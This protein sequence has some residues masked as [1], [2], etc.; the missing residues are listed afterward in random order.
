MD[1]KE[2]GEFNLIGRI[3]S[4]VNV[5]TGI[6]GIGD[7]CAVLPQ[8]DSFSTLVSTDMLVEGTHF[9]P[10]ADPYD[11]GWKSAAVNLSDIAA[12]GGKPEGTLLAFALTDRV[13]VGF[14]DQFIKGYTELSVLFDAPL[15]GGDTTFSTT[16]ISIC[17]TVLGSCPS[18]REMKRDGAKPGDMVCVTGTLGDSAAGLRIL[19][20]GGAS[21][22]MENQLVLRHLRPVPRVKE[23]LALASSGAL[24]SM[25]DISDGIG[26]DL[27]HILEAS[28]VGAEIDCSAIPLSAELKN[29]CSRNGLDPLELAIGGG[30]DYELLFTVPEAGEKS[31]DVPHHIIGRITENGLKWSDGKDYLGFRHF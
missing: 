24:R 30:E 9:L 27:R 2:L 12:M 31:L 15:L 6:T 20:G 25:M 21:D 23:G 10:D 11:L 5:P 26:S 19:L 16:G 29:Y 7:D 18:G 13:D 14:V 3:K 1:L 8:K 22:D 4:S 17:V 28:G